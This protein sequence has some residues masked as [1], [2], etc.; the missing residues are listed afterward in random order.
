[1]TDF[2]LLTINNITRETKDA[3][4]ISFKIPA[5]L[6][7]DFKFI[8]GQYLVVKTRIDNKEIR[9][10]Y[11]ICSAPNSESLRIAIKSLKGGLF[12]KYANTK[13]K[14]GDKLEVSKPQGRF[15]LNT[16]YRNKKEYLAFVAGSGITPVMAMIYAV[17]KDE[18]KSK[19]VLV[20]ANKTEL[21]VIFKNELLK[22]K[23]D[24]PNRFFIQNVFSRANVAEA[25]FGRIDKGIINYCIKNRFKNFNFDS[26]YLCGPEGMIK[27]V[28]ESLLDQKVL[29]DNI[30]F[31]LFTESKD[32]NEVSGTNAIATIILDDET[33]KIAI[34]K[35]ESI[36]EAA[37]AA[38]LD[39]PYSCKGGICASCMAKITNG[40][41]K[42]T[43]N[44]VLTDD[45]IS[46]GFVLTC[47]AQPTTKEITVD[48]D[49]LD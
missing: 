43:K 10:S 18:A 5:K 42:M 23:Q 47:Q 19:F 1:M 45:E 49:E 8:A 22:L 12:S 26:Y 28:K 24:Y 31:E 16:D 13:L 6:K 4:V 14:I 20:Y 30:H 21:D 46:E 25:L 15:I 32:K 40:E 39:A 3:V 27:T 34:K 29:S 17:L 41:A 9:R 11:S 2:F 7:D 48:Y 36:L 38:G 37:L 44:M 33:F 35:N